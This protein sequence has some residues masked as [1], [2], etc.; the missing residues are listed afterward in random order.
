MG[1]M[2]SYSQAGQD[3]FV[4]EMTEQKENGFFLDIGCSDAKHH[5]NTYALEQKGWTGLLVDILG[6][7][8]HR[9][10]IFVQCD[11][12]HPNERLIFNYDHLPPVVDYLSLDVDDAL[13]PVFTALPWGVTFRVMTIEHDGYRKGPADRDKTRTM[14]KA[15]GY[16]LV[17]ADVKVEWPNPG[18]RSEYE[19]WWVSP[20]HVNPDL[21]KKYQC[22]GRYW[23]N[24]LGIE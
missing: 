8:E 23:K 12:A 6:G 11:A 18:D 3:S 5:S 16:H 17:C 1:Q 9:K 10:G 15:M 14:L 19:D 13:M 4:W 24:I 7:C 22:Q 2:K 20:E 21:V